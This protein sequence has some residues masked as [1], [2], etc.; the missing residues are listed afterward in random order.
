MKRHRSVAAATEASLADAT[1]LTESDA[2]AVAMLRRLAKAADQVLQNGGLTESGNFDNVTVPTYLRY[3]EALAL[4]PAS[5]AR[6]S[7]TGR[8]DRT[9]NGKLAEIRGLRGVPSRPTKATRRSS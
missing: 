6:L 9:G 4:T 8:Q 1:H 7:V 2:G 3:C 5:R